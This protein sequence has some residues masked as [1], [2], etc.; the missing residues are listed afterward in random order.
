M[1]AVLDGFL[2]FP[3]LEVHIVSSSRK[4]VSAPEKLAGNLWFHSQ[5]VPKIG[6]LRTG[7]QGCIRATRK[8]LR[9]IQPDIVHGQGTESDCSISA[10]LSGF[11]NVV[12][13]HGNMV[14]MA[15]VMKARFGSFHWCTARLEN[16]V[17][18][19]TSGVF[20]NSKFTEQLVRPRARRTWLVPNALRPDFFRSPPSTET[21]GRCILV[22]AG[23]VCENKQ[24][25]KMLQLAHSLHRK[26]LD[27][28]LHFVGN[29]LHG[30]PYARAFL[31]QIQ[32]A[33]TEGYARYLGMK[34]AA[35]L[36]GCF[37][38]SSALVHTPIAESFG[39]VVAEAL[40]RNLRFFGF[41][42]GGVP[43]IVEGADGAVLVPPEDWAGLENAIEAWLK[44][45]HPA[46]RPTADLIK[47]R[48]HPEAIARRHITIYREVLGGQA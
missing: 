9:Q 15:R 38:R 24:Q 21:P 20:C 33:E 35:E 17:L 47:Q 13:L 39:L 6:W 3:E 23:V 27:F 44:S 41:R 30:S 12:T 18:R 5:Y 1:Q 26:K 4:P 19:R 2:T 29:A 14:E 45:G 46:S 42:V 43:D 22:H 8:R 34:P 16:F 7:Y 28:E 36:I 11:T 37:D 10:V 48:Y 31:E 25:M 40:S 32:G